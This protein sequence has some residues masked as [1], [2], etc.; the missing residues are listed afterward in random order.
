MLDARIA[1]GKAIKASLDKIDKEINSKAKQGYYSITLTLVSENLVPLKVL[2]AK[3]YK[4]DIQ[5]D[6]KKAIV[7]WDV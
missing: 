6:K 5:E 3:G 4:I 7:S 2:R 1:K